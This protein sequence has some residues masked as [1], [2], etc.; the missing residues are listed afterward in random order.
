MQSLD[1]VDFST[2][3][4]NKGDYPFYNYINATAIMTFESTATASLMKKK[5]NMYFFKKLIGI[6]RNFKTTSFLKFI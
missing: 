1:T 3:D 5:Q 6:I 2:K 4:I